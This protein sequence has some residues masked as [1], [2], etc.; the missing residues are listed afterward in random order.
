MRKYR[1]IQGFNRGIIGVAQANIER[2]ALD[3]ELR[4]W[5]LLQSSK[6]VPLL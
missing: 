6:W 3:S 4:V 5:A 1:H 2:K